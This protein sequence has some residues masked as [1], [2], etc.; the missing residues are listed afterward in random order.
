MAF[1]GGIRVLWTL[2]LVWFCFKG[3]R[4]SNEYCKTL[5]ISGTKISRFN[6]GGYEYMSSEN[7]QK[8]M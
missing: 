8:A 1:G 3:Y 5:N 6:F 4:K 2:F 7:K